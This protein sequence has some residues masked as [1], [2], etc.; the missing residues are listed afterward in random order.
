MIGK[1]YLDKTSMIYTCNKD[2]YFYHYYQRLCYIPQ[3]NYDK[4]LTAIHY[5]L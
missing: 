2:W 5:F 4:E 1:I 3:I